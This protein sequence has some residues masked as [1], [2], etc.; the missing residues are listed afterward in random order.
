MWSVCVLDLRALS[1]FGVVLDCGQPLSETCSR[2][3]AVKA[4][5]AIM[6]CSWAFLPLSGR[7]PARAPEGASDCG[8][9]L[10]LAAIVSEPLALPV[11][12]AVLSA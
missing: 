1:L 11:V 10:R 2:L 7:S 9:L 12:D 3:L 4:R 8:R 5:L 6:S